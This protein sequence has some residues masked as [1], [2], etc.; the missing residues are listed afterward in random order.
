M[1][2]QKGTVFFNFRDASNISNRSDRSFVMIDAIVEEDGEENAVPVEIDNATN[3]KATG[4]MLIQKD[5]K[6]VSD[7]L[8]SKA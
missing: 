2:S 3:Y 4:E 5:E 6:I 1:N 8:C 7:T